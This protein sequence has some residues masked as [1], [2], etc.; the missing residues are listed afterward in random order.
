MLP[1]TTF[2]PPKR[3]TPRRRPSESRPLREE[4]PAFLCAI[5]LL[6]S[7]WLGD[8]LFDLDHRQILTMTVLAT[9]I[10]AAA[11]LEDDQMFAAALLHD[12]A[13]NLGAGNGR[14]ADLVAHHQDVGEL[15]LGAGFAL[16]TL[17]GERVVGGDRVLFSTRA[18]NGDHET[19]DLGSP[20]GAC[21]TTPRGMARIGPQM[22]ESMK[23]HGG[24]ERPA[25]GGRNIRRERPEST[26]ETPKSGGFSRRRRHCCRPE[27][28]PL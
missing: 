6:R 14:L 5:V 2:W 27:N 7:L 20:T 24:P 22:P 12:R 19:P 8:D 16:E 4:P 15:D 9:R 1:D 28:T 13:D 3:F 11:L 21:P 26:P 23:E 10:L 17:N 25:E 18:D